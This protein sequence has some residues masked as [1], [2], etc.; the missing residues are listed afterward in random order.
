MEKIRKS[1]IK[2]FI[3]KYNW[4]EI[5]YPSGKD[6]WKKFE[7]NNPTIALYMLYVKKMNTYPAKEVLYLRW[8]EYHLSA[9]FGTLMTQL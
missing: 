5:N 8:N 4:K 2:P 3:N 9:Y 7:K 1:K 6:D